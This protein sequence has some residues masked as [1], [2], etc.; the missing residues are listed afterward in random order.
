MRSVPL[1]LLIALVTAPSAAGQVEL[2]LQGQPYFGGD[3]TLT[4][5]DVGLANVSQ[6]VILALGLNPLPLDA[7]VP[8]GKGPWYV[9]TLVNTALVGTIPVDGDFRLDFT[10]PPE[11]PAP[12]GIPIV[13]EAYVGG[14]FTN[15]AT[16]PLDEPYYEPA[17]A[18][19]LAAASPQQLSYFGDRN[20]VGDFN[21]D[22]HP[23][24]VAGAWWQD[25]GGA[26]KAGAVHVFWG[27][28]FDTVTVLTSPT[29]AATHYF[30]LDL[31]VADVD[32]D[33]VD[34]L[35]VGEGG[36]SPA[37]V[38]AYGHLYV[39]RGAASFS[40]VPAASIQGLTSEP[41]VGLF[42]RQIHAGDLD[43]DGAV[44]L[45]AG[46]PNS[47]FNGI[48]NEGHVEVFYGPQ[49]DRGVIVSSPDPEAN[50]FFGS[51]VSCADVTGDGIADL[52]EASGR[53]DAGGV[54]NVGRAHVFDGPT[55]QPILTLENPLPDG[56]NSRFGNAI[57]GAD[58]DG[59]G[60]AEIVVTDERDHAFVF[61]SPDYATYTLIHRPPPPGGPG[62]TCASFGYY[63]AAGD[64]NGDG[65]LDI[66]IAE[67]YGERV[68]VALGPY[69]QTVRT[70]MDQVPKSGAEFGW[71]VTM[72]DVNE[73]GC[74]D[75]IV[76]SDLADVGSTS[77]GGHIT[78][79]GN[80]PR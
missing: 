52:L 15:P 62:S 7:P 35:V 77:G 9:G 8:T 44:D 71:G 34:D 14:Q 59:D 57:L 12:V 78:V 50:D 70:V 55:L 38:G 29:P 51:R 4:V 60:L 32:G 43:G 48:S 47:S 53:E 42:G 40:Q 63:M 11:T 80:A 69:W 67:P 22:G 25:V 39:F 23:D 37:P 19:V 65:V 76:G 46:L 18:V 61:R 41:A 74:D 10:M 17:A 58:A 68:H 54:V 13:L 2:G 1:T 33:M 16:V 73:D 49:Y 28:S 21:A 36:G 31:A 27:P 26:V 5:E 79:F 24:I 3:A 45:I 75:L 6:P 30:G 66:V 56:S 20:A 64:A 72:A